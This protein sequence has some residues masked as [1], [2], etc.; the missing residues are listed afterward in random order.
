MLGQLGRQVG[1]ERRVDPHGLWHTHVAEF[2]GEGVDVGITSKQLGHRF[3]A[4][5]AR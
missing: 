2:R 3:I 1:I 4:T 5:T